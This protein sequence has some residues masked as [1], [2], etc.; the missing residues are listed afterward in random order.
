MRNLEREL[1]NLIRKAVKEL[2]T[3]KKKAIAVTAANLADYLGVPKYR[4]GEVED[5]PRTSFLACWSPAQAAA[6][7]AA[8]ESS[9]CS[10]R[11][12]AR[13]IWRKFSAT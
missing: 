3:S 8:G 9:G 2:M 12:G 13:S 1:S 10:R 4:Y 7:G 5:V 11:R 6:R